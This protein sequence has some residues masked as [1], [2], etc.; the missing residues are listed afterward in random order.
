[1]SIKIRVLH[2]P[3]QMNAD[4]I[5]YTGE[6][7]HLCEQAKELLIPLLQQKGLVLREVNIDSNET[8]KERYGLRIPVVLLPDGHEKG[9]PFTAAQISR[10][11]G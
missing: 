5:I 10:L 11:L 6:H 2:G 7:C 9:W 3:I 8:L 4:L 1:L